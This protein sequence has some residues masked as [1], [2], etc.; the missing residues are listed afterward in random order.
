MEENL[1]AGHALRGPHY[2]AF[3]APAMTEGNCAV[4]THRALAALRK[5]LDKDTH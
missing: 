3:D 1:D 4:L 2:A 5:Q